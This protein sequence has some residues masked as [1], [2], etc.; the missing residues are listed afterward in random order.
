ME[1]DLRGQILSHA[2]VRS[3]T[4]QRVTWVMRPQGSPLPAVVLHRIT[5]GREYTYAGRID[6]VSSL[7]QID[8]WGQSYAQAKSVSRAV[9][10]AL[11]ALTTPFQGAFVEDE[12]DT[13]ERGE[14][15][16]TTSGTPD[17]YR[18]SLDVRVWHH[19]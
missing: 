14:A 13:Y 6:L 8:C 16:P 18:T 10:A 12:R 15:P 19:P 3:L 2:A 4:G 9:I 5:G 17:F 1:E 7:V 11:D